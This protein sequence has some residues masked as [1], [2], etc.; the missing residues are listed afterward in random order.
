MAY[1]NPQ[2][3]LADVEN[4]SDAALERLLAIPTFRAWAERANAACNAEAEARGVA[5]GEVEGKAK[6]RAEDLLTYFFAKSDS[7][8][9]NALAQI[10]GCTDPDTLNGWLHRA[11]HGETSA[12]IFDKPQA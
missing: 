4:M 3:E 12:E 8:S 5:K 7:P 9:P 11:Y 2:H 1:A 6:G 10:R